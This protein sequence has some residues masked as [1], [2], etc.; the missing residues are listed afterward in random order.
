MKVAETPRA[1]VDSLKEN[2]RMPTLPVPVKA[3]LVVKLSESRLRADAASEASMSRN[4]PAAR[5]RLLTVRAPKAEP[6][7]TTAPL[8]V[9]RALRVPKPEAVAPVA[10][11]T[12]PPTVPALTKRPVPETVAVTLP[13]VAVT[14]PA[15]I[16]PAVTV[17]DV[18]TV[19]PAAARFAI[20]PV[21]VTVPALAVTAPERLP[22]LTSEPEVKVVAP[23]TTAPASSFKVPPVMLTALPAAR[24]PVGAMSRIPAVTEVVPV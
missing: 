3:E 4:E 23:A 16:V 7:L 5:E 9:V 19:A 2:R 15:E 1:P 6:G 17:P 20:V 22:A 18:L 21:L 14:V 12:V 10:T 24:L 13:P 8:C 11:L